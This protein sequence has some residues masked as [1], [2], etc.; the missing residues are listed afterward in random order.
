MRLLVIDDSRA[1][2]RLLSG[3][4]EEIGIQSAPAADGVEALEAFERDSN[5]D[6]A[7][8]DWDMPRMNGLEFVKAVRGRSEH[9]GK[10]L[11]MVTAQSSMANVAEAMNAG[12]NDYLMK[13]LTKEMLAEK[14][15][16]VGLID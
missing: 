5:F 2:R 16:L 7:L 9:N 11:I 1:V 15:R 14:L 3:F 13:P 6:G 10:K 12:A 8:V 4:L